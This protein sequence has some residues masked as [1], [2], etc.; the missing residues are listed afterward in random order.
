MDALSVLCRHWKRHSCQS[1]P[2]PSGGRLY[3]VFFLYN[4]VNNPESFEVLLKKFRIFSPLRP[5]E[6]YLP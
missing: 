5:L 1:D 2:F 6:V 4:N 3:S